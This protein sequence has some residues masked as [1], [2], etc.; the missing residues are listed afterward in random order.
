MFYKKFSV[1]LVS[2]WGGFRPAGLEMSARPVR[3]SIWNVIL[4]QPKCERVEALNGP[5]QKNS[6]RVEIASNELLDNNLRGIIFE[7]PLI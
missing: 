7:E 3:I 2:F 5:G 1:V 4:S 6:G